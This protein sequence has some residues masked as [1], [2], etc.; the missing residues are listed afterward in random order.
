MKWEKLFVYNWKISNFPEIRKR[1]ELFK[2]DIFIDFRS[3]D[4]FKM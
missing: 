4:F 2:T 1:Y 3:C